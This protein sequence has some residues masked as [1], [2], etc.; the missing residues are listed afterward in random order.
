M[1]LT[2]AITL[3]RRLGRNGIVLLYAL[4]HPGTP[5]GVK[6]GILAMIAYVLSP[7]DLVPDMLMIV[8]LT[9]DLAVL[10]VGIPYLMKKL[11]AN[12]QVEINQKVGSLIFENGPKSGYHGFGTGQ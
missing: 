5:R 9:D 12:V 8:G 3:L 1:W 11:P 7:I 6:F 10:L 4:R 2:R